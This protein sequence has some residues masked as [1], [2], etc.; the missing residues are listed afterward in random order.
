LLF[1]DGLH[2]LLDHKG[3]RMEESAIRSAFANIQISDRIL[4]DLSDGIKAMS[5]GGPFLDDVAAISIQRCLL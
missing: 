1:T 5:D 2:S 3:H 4:D